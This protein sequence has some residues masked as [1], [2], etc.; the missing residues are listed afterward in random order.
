M[1]VKRTRLAPHAHFGRQCP[2]VCGHRKWCVPVCRPPGVSPC[3]W[4]RLIPRDPTECQVCPLAT[5]L[6][7]SC[8]RKPGVSPGQLHPL[9]SCTWPVA[10]RWDTRSNRHTW[11]FGLLVNSASRS[12]ALCCQRTTE[13]CVCRAA[14]SQRV[15]SERK[16]HR[17]PCMGQ[18][19]RGERQSALPIKAKRVAPAMSEET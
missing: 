9:A 17:L 6:A 19:S 5:A 1:Q 8:D 15:C 16:R 3:H 13:T 10:L 14:S 12:R 2:F 7:S 4:P 18:L 11:R